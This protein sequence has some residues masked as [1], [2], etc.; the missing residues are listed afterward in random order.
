MSN[1]KRIED[2][3][4]R[5]AKC[6]ADRDYFE[7]AHKQMREEVDRLSDEVRELKDQIIQGNSWRA[8]KSRDI[9]LENERLVGN[10]KRILRWNEELQAKVDYLTEEI[11]KNSWG[12]AKFM[13][14]GRPAAYWKG[15][16]RTLEGIKP[17]ASDG[18]QCHLP[19]VYNKTSRCVVNTPWP[20][21]F[22]ERETPKPPKVAIDE[23][24]IGPTGFM[25]RELNKLKVRKYRRKCRPISC[26]ECP[27]ERVANCNETVEAIQYTGEN[28]VEIMAF[29]PQVCRS[30]RGGLQC[31]IEHRDIGPGQ[32]FIKNEEIH[33]RGLCDDVFH[34]Q[35]ELV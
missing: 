2:L 31:A 6:A 13:F 22:E 24:Y 21:C 4:S 16:E 29:M 7:G 15:L 9:E 3:L 20:G 33:T 8:E 17:K 30:L 34:A 26:R 23:D 19:C 1:K 14:A 5:L 27:H 28:E 11:A 18:V 35:Y 32:W 12:L 25:H 10:N